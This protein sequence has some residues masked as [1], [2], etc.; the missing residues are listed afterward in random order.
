MATLD[1]VKSLLGNPTDVDD[2]L[3]TII[4][5]TESRFKILINTD[6]IPDNLDYVVTEVSIKRFNRIGSEG[7]SSHSVEGESLSF[8]DDDFSQYKPD[9]RAYLESQKSDLATLRFY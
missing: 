4:E 6:T 9:I 8:S 2:K 7:L 5:L 1:K 3:N